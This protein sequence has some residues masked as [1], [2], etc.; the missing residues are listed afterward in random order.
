MV[1]VRVVLVLFLVAAAFGF[2]GLADA[3]NG[4]SGTVGVE[5]MFLPG[6]STDVWINL[7]WNLD[8]LSFGNLVEISVFPGFAVSWTGTV[9]YS[10]GPV[11]LRGTVMLDVYPFAFA[12]VDFYAA[13]GLF[14]I[15]SDGFEASADASLFSAIYPAFGNTLSLD[16]DASYG[17]FSLWSDVDL[18]I[19]GF[20]VS[21][22]VGGEV[23]V[24][25]L[26]LGNGGLTVDLGASTFV[27]P[28]VDAQMWLDM[29]ITLGAV[30][31]TSETDF[32]L[33]PFGLTQQRFE[34]KIGS[35]GLSVYVWGS[36]TGA[37]DLSAGIGGTYDF[38]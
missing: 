15:A 23:R 27:L 6:F 18:D 25:D 5:A 22:L 31:V 8:G 10:F 29:A 34:A 17:V 11:D 38:P 28:A 21:V 1:R 32:T 14:D 3:S 24:L 4:L 7:D 20:G 13:V 19:P 2:S 37:G 26:D 35:N 9:G 36:F 33:T 30:T 12:G 16:V